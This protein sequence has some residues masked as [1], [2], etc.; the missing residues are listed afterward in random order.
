MK[1]QSK[2]IVPVKVEVLRTN[3]VEAIEGPRPRTPAEA[4]KLAIQQEVAEAMASKEGFPFEPWF[5]SRQV[6]IELRRLQTVPE[7][8]RWAIFFEREGCI[9]C[10]KRD[11][12]HASKGF[13]RRC[14]QHVFNVLKEIDSELMQEPAGGV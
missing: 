6:A 10:H 12:S 4:L 14:E 3:E 2:A 11:Q 7:R 9:Y 1:R 13:C 8:K 5:R